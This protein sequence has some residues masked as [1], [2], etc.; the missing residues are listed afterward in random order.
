MH[1][2]DTKSG[3][4]KVDEWSPGQSVFSACH[5][6]EAFSFHLAPRKNSRHPERPTMRLTLIDFNYGLGFCK[7]MGRELAPVQLFNS[8]SVKSMAR[9]MTIT[10]NCSGNLVKVSDHALRFPLLYHLDLHPIRCVVAIPMHEI[11]QFSTSSTSTTACASYS[12]SFYIVL[13]SLNK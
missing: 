5:P 3:N 10:P 6:E 13:N 4:W 1:S 7:L 8:D 12:M 2:N 9:R 11:T